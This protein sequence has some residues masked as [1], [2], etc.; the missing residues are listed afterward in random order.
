[1]RQAIIMRIKLARGTYHRQTDAFCFAF[2][3][4]DKKTQIKESRSTMAATT[5]T[6]NDA[7]RRGKKEITGGTNNKKVSTSNKKEASFN[8]HLERA[9]AAVMQNKVATETLH[10]QWR[11]SLQRLS[12]LLV[13]I[14]LHQSQGPTQA[15]L[16]D[17]KALNQHYTLEADS[18]SDDR[19]ISG[20]DAFL[21]VLRD[22]VVSV[23][24][25][26]MSA[27][28][29]YFT[30][31]DPHGDFTSHA[32]MM[33]VACIPPI[34]SLHFKLGPHE[35]AVDDKSCLDVELLNQ[36]GLEPADRLRGFPVVLAFFVVL[37]VS[38][39]FMDLQMQ[40]HKENAKMVLKLQ[41]D[42]DDQNKLQQEEKGL[43]K[44]K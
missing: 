20:Y 3:I 8:E 4:T 17:I 35:G 36:A 39:F 28:L 29:A 12:F 1:M 18:S 2:R 38:Y 5:S 26:V 9:Q 19:M 23:M 11:T 37:T 30:S 32:Y 40:K 6:S 24:G 16:Q 22:G 15:C 25:L 10:A 13:I 33:A 34:I 44:K 31:M 14:S 41:K 27:S 7:K 43:K 21:L 42:L